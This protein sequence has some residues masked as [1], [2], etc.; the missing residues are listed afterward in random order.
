ML[1]RRKQQQQLEQGRWN[2]R[3]IDCA[4]E[5]ARAA[6]GRAFSSMVLIIRELQ[7]FH[8]G[9]CGRRSSTRTC[10]AS[11]RASTPRC[12]PPSSGSSSTSSPAPRPS[13]SSLMLLLAN[14]TVYSM[15][16][17]VAAA[18]SLVPTT[19]GSRGDG[20]HPAATG[21]TAIPFP[22]AVRHPRAQDVLHWPHGL[23]GW[24][25]RRGRQSA[26]S[27]RRHRRRPV[28]RVVASAKRSGGA[29]AGRVAVAGDATGV[30]VRLDGRGGCTSATDCTRRRAGHLETDIR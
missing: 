10:R 4:G 6:V 15:G 28:G 16:D 8:A 29:A 19:P 22:A 1:K 14:F 18:A 9:R 21:A 25:R 11:W 27:C 3:L 7:S 20:G 26:A 5:S 2:E 24:K 17:S 12:T 23:S 30:R 13:W